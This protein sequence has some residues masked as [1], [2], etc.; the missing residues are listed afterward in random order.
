MET[1]VQ[2][3]EPRPQPVPRPSNPDLRFV[4]P[5]HPNPKNRQRQDILKKG[6]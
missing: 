6:L 2:R 4:P 1:Q 3:P 5:I